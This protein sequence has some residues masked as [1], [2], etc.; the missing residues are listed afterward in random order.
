MADLLI[1]DALFDEA[2]FR[3]AFQDPDLE[4]HLD[5]RLTPAGS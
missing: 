5:G 1:G 4:P 3:D 2:L